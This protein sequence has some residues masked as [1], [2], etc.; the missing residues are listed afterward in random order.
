MKRP[1]R[2]INSY[3]VSNS[4]ID[5][6]SESEIQHIRRKKF[7]RFNTSSDSDVSSN[8]VQVVKMK[9]NILEE[10]NSAVSI[11]QVILKM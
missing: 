7:R 3:D 8:D 9:Y 1:R 5:S 4:D 10:K 11:S 6:S 2:D